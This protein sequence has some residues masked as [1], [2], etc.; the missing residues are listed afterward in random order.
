[1]FEKHPQGGGVEVLVDKSYFKANRLS[2]NDTVD[3]V[4]EG[5]KVSLT[6]TGTGT[7]PEFIYAMKD[8][9]TL[10]PDPETFGLIMMPL[11]QAQQVLNL[12]GQINQVVIKLSPGA[13]EEKTAEQVRALLDPYGNLSSYPLKKQ[14]SHAVLQGELDGLR[15]VSTFMPVIF[16]GIAAA[17]QMVMLGR[18]IAGQRLQIGIMKAL[19]YNSRQIMTYYTA[20][21]LS[22]S[23]LGALLGTIMGIGLS[24]AI[25]GMYA[26]FFNLPRAIGGVNTAAVINGLLLS[27][28]VGA[29]AGIAASRK[30]VSFNPAESMRPALG[31]NPEP[32]Q[33][34]SGAPGIGDHRGW[35]PEGS[36]GGGE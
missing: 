7:G 17:I 36:H 10:L 3:M 26:D 20:Y 25:S 33:C 14:L 24:S 13:D 2:F 22:S 12:P 35:R 32:P 29:A 31:G 19:G 30:V 34:S 15:A 4:A 28:S 16:L 27:L 18:M 11:N 9:S 23:L 5:R 21:S 1:M 6:V 8:A